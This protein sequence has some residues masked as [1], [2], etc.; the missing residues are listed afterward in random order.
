MRSE[1]VHFRTFQLCRYYDYVSF[2]VTRLPCE[3]VRDNQ[4][5]APEERERLNLKR[6]DASSGVYNVLDWG[7]RICTTSAKL[8][9]LEIFN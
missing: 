4:G 5:D 9:F 2:S 8:N 3:A 1:H 7:L 6:S